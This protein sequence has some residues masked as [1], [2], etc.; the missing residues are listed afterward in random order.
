[1][2]L[3]LKSEVDHLGLPGDVVD[4]ADGYGRNFLIPRGKAIIAT[5]G[6]MKEAEALTRSRK[7][8]EAKTVDTAKSSKEVLESRTLRIPVRVDDRGG[9]YGSVSANDVQRVLK[10]RGHDIPRKRIDLRGTIKQI[11]SYEIPVQV[12]PQVVATVVVDVVDEEGKIIVNA[13][14]AIVDTEAVKDAEAVAAAAAEAAGDTETDVDVLAEQ[15][16]EA[17]TA[18]EAEQAA[19][20]Q[21]EVDAAEAADEVADET[22]EGRD[23]I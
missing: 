10:E 23:Q 22:T 13:G 3:I 20:E 14:G 7:A 18:Y 17:A 16:L 19:A 8:Q 11:G 9:L 12:H 21:V 6:A 4:V 15:A 2:K 5:K 1:V